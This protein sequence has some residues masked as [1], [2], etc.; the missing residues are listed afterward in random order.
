MSDSKLLAPGQGILKVIAIIG[1]ALS[2]ISGLMMFIGAFAEEQGGV[3]S[4]QLPSVYYLWAFVLLC[5]G[6]YIYI[7][8]LIHC[9][10]LEKASFLLILGIIDLCL[11]FVNAI[12]D[13]ILV[14]L[15]SVMMLPILLALP[16]LYI[17]GASKNKKMFE[18]NSSV[19]NESKI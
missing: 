9:K 15:S 6:V 5:Y 4:P 3:A 12:V 18:S 11:G 19:S 17:V 2:G 8:A 16:I 1:L 13:I 10:N 14:G 7:M